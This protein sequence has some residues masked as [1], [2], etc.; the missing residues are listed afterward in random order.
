LIEQFA[1]FFE[2]AEVDL[3]A[4]EPRTAPMDILLGR[5]RAQASQVIKQAD[6]LMIFHLLAGR[7]PRE[8]IERNFRYYEPRT[9]HGS[10]LSP[11]THALVAARLGDMN[12]AHRYFH[13][14]AEIDLG[15]G[16]GN[17]AG[18]VHAAAC[19]GL[20]QATVLGFAGAQSRDGRLAFD[21]RLP[22]EWERLQ[23]SLVYRRRGLRIVV[24]ERPL[25]ARIVLREGDQPLVIDLGS[26]RAQVT[27]ESPV[28][29]ICVNGAWQKEGGE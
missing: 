20:W 26:L 9:G 1:G 12:T 5:E 24:T 28:E 25:R 14:A 17:A 15:R 11:A 6:V 7:H 2:L 13:Q 23:I 3:K 18:G 21:P 4:F 22:E 29:A 8:V 10:S 16:V 19:G 27:P